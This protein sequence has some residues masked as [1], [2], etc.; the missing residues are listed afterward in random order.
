MTDKTNVEIIGYK[1]AIEEMRSLL[2]QHDQSLQASKTTARQVLGSSSLVFALFG[3]FQMFI[4]LPKW[5]FYYWIALS[6]I[7][8]LYILLILLCYWVISLSIVQTP[9]RG[10]WD[11]LY[12]SLIKPNDE[13]SILR[14]QLSAYLDVLELN[15]HKIELRAVYTNISVILLA[16]VIISM[17]ILGI[18]TKTIP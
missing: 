11:N 14:N 5:D 3:T 18:A 2:I 15:R 4:E 17:I 6:T 7:G 16:V 10:E 13:R 9:I 8:L 1:I 12:Y